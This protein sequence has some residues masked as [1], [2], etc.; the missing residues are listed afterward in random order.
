MSGG[1]G[2]LLAAMGGLVS[3]ATVLAIIFLKKL[4]KSA[5][6]DEGRDKAKSEGKL[7]YQ[8]LIDISQNPYDE[9]DKTHHNA[10]RRGWKMAEE[11]R[12]SRN[13]K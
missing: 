4:A 11:T 12:K 7:A 1:G 5:F 10:W 3:G 2:I 6:V 9:T 13:L 8:N